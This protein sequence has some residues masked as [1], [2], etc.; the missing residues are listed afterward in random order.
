MLKTFLDISRN[1]LTS[2]SGIA[3]GPE[4]SAT[5]GRGRNRLKA[6]LSGIG[7]WCDPWETGNFKAWLTYWQSP[8]PSLLLPCP[9][10]C[11]QPLSTPRQSLKSSLPTAALY[12]P[13]QC[14]RSTSLT[15]VSTASE[16]G[17]YLDMCCTASEDGKKRM[18][19][20]S[21]TDACLSLLVNT[22]CTQHCHVRPLLRSAGEQ[23]DW[24]IGNACQR[25]G[26]NS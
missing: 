4:D 19:Y 6:A 12:S 26:Q 24:R 8:Q 25:G 9:W 22:N 10:G 5:Q 17:K 15:F 21:A 2:P 11:L 14:N 3:K 23:Y 16:D 20:S 1:A 13:L 18:C 7:K